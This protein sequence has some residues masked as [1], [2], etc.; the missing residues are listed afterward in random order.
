MFLLAL[1]H[2]SRHNGFQENV[3]IL[4]CENVGQRREDTLQHP[5]I[6]AQGHIQMWYPAAGS[7]H[8]PEENSYEPSELDDL[9]QSL[10]DFLQRLGLLRALI[11]TLLQ[12]L[13]HHVA[14]RGMLLFMSFENETHQVQDAVIS[15]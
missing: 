4:L 10:A 11:P 12:I 9:I 8:A 13:A 14:V 3:L 2:C 6:V 5:A 1:C 15:F 7:V